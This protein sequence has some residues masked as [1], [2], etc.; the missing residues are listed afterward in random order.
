MFA[1]WGGLALPGMPAS[2]MRELS[3]SSM[4]FG[5]YP[6]IKK[7]IVG[8]STTDIGILKKLPIG[9]LS[10]GIGAA[11]AN[12]FD[13][14]KIKFQRETGK[15]GADG[16][17][18]TG[19]HKGRKPTYTGTFNALATIYQKGGIPGL[20][21]GVTATIGRAA[22][23]SGTQLAVYDHSKYL[24][25]K[26][27]LFEEGFKLHVFSSLI[28]AFCTMVTTQ[29]FDTVKTRYMTDHYSGAHLYKNPID[30]AWKTVT[31]EGPFGLYR[32]A[33]PSVIRFGFHFVVAL[34]LWEQVRRLLGLGY[35]K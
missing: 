20:Y 15:L 25:K 7:L 28:S 34:P 18:Q 23:L 2:M 26:N 8:D 3:Y 19:L 5:L 29:P 31:H 35:L 1:R 10:G 12:P 22:V 13:L 4:R 11:L 9:M 33:L 27:G 14:V 30:C 6:P 24:L 21:R 17:Y 32:G 16:I